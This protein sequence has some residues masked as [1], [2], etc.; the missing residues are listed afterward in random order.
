MIGR[1]TQAERVM[2]LLE[3]NYPSWLTSYEISEQLSILKTSLNGILYFQRVDKRI[4]RRV[5]LR[6]S[7]YEW[8]FA[9]RDLGLTNPID[10][11]SNPEVGK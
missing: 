3:K 1:K 2:E 9:A 11:V 4:E 5:S 6:Y 8:R 7:R 10:P